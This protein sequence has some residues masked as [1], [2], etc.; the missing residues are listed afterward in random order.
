MYAHTCGGVPSKND[1]G[2]RGK[3]SI[4]RHNTRPESFALEQGVNGYQQFFNFRI[5]NAE[6]DDN[7]FNIL[8]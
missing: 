7:D 1:S 2:G 4:D 8:W 3:R 5:T 6:D